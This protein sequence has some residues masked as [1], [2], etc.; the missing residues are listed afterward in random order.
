MMGIHVR[1]ACGKRLTVALRHR[2]QIIRCKS[3]GRETRV[4]RLPL[5]SLRVW[6][7]AYPVGAALAAAILWGLGD[8]WWPA[9][10]LLFSGRWVLLLPLALLVPLVLLRAPRLLVPLVIG[11]TIVVGPVM[12]FRTGLGAPG[13]ALQGTP[14]RI[15]SFN[16]NGGD[17][18]AFVLNE[19][20]DEW[21]ADV[22]ALQ[23]CGNAIGDATRRLDGWFVHRVRRLCFLS[24]FPIVDT[25]VMDRRGFAISEAAG[26][27]GI[28]GAA[29]VARYRL[30]TPAG[31]L[32]VTNLHLETPRKG[33][34]GA[35]QGELNTT[36]LSDNT[37][38]RRFEAEHA[39]RWV[40]DG[41]VPLVV[42]GDFNT[43]VESRI[44]AANWGS[45]VNAFSRVGRGFGATRLNGW[46]RVRIDHVLTR[47]N[48]SPV[49]VSLG[50]PLESDHLPVIADLVITSE[51]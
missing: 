7:W 51:R 46:I 15:V 33:L 48:I 22:V 11:A 34:E 29:D 18:I 28:G 27:A 38:L 14:L 12:G 42:A 35:L 44:Y 19:V 4:P 26:S 13:Q 43:P 6:A 36:K 23:E 16:L 37:T 31:P 17:A 25:A 32:S 39:S 9:T 47:G 5:P 41:G 1:C 40:N 21:E 20:L 49:R 30:A 24:R 2:G 3:C 50:R 10:V 8:A 45:F